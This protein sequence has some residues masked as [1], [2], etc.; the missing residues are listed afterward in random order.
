MAAR[1]AGHND[2]AA[3]AMADQQVGHMERPGWEE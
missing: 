3:Y 2:V 1:R